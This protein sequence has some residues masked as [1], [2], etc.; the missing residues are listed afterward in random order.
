MEKSKHLINNLIGAGVTE[1]YI[2]TILSAIEAE[3][4]IEKAELIGKFAKEFSTADNFNSSYL[5]NFCKI[6]AV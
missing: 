2:N 4:K 1:S 6:Q 3:K 5:I